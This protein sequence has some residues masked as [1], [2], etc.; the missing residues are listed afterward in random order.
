MKKEYTKPNMLV[1]ELRHRCRLLDTSEVTSVNS[2]SG[3]KY[4]GSDDGY[5]GIIK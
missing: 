5:D 4:G 2:N 1:V 3:M